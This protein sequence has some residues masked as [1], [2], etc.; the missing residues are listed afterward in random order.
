MT[1]DGLFYKSSTKRSHIVPFFH[2]RI[3]KIIQPVRP[4]SSCKILTINSDFF[5]WIYKIIQV[6][7]S[8]TPAGQWGTAWS[9]DLFLH[10]TWRTKD[11]WN[12]EV[13]WSVAALAE[14][15]TFRTDAIQHSQQSMWFP[16][17]Q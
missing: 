8:V 10:L 6:W 14:L 9:S 3:Y 13:L 1:L 11:F 12:Y 15:G 4:Q 2:P 17:R 7:V 16:S 5:A